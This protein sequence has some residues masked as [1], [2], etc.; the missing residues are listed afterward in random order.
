[1]R[2]IKPEYLNEALDYAPAEASGKVSWISPSNIAL[3]KYWG[4]KGEQ[5]P[6]NPSLSFTLDSSVTKTVISYQYVENINFPRVNFLF[7]GKSDEKFEN[8]ISAYLKIIEPY[9]P[10]LKQLRLEI[11]SENT[12]PHSAGIA[13]SASS[14]AA[15][16]LGICN[17][18]CKFKGISTIGAD[19]FRKSSFMARLGSGSA[20][21]S[22]YGGYNAWGSTA[23]SE[24]SSDEY[25]IH[26]S[27]NLIHPV[28]TDLKDS[29]LVVQSGKKNVSSSA[30]HDL[31][32][33][34]PFASSRFVQARNN[35]DD[36]TVALGSGDIPSFIEIVENEAL[37]LHAMMLSSAPGYILLHSNS[38]EIIR[39][40]RKFREQQHC[41]VC[42]T[43]DA[44]PNIHVLYFEKD[45][46]KIQYFIKT[47]LA[48]LCENQHWINDQLG[49]GPVGLTEKL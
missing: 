23:A 19:F 10:F 17:I 45:I 32:N 44:G 15:L 39:R 13:S 14:F 4:K 37:S 36:L 22:V 8:R 31:M 12:F 35:F 49:K 2:L 48:D 41:D 6:Q 29:I 20:C 9:F 34:H 30:G 42:F 28:F 5:Y 7:Q 38:I 27:Q 3:V 21:R 26:L 25:A 18:E 16:A 46:E 47:E 24:D 33:G 43:I 1:M 11:H 40:I